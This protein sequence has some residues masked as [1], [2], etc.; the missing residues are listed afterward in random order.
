MLRRIVL[1]AAAIV[2]AACQRPAATTEV[3]DAS[4]AVDAKALPASFDYGL[5]DTDSAEPE[6]FYVEVGDAPTQGP[7][8]AAITIVMFSDFE[9]PFCIQGLQTVQTLFERYPGKIRFAY[10]AFPLD[11]H[12]NALLAAMAARTAQAQGKFWPF[13]NLLFSQRGI[14]PQRVF[15]YAEQA[16]LDVPSLIKDLDALEFGPEVS[17][18]M[19]QARR[20]GVRS[21]P[22]F[23]INGREI[24]GAKPIAEFE[25]LID[26]ELEL[27]ESWLQAGTPLKDVYA[28]AIED[29]YRKVEFTRR[30]G[31]DPDKVFVVPIADSPRRGPDTAPVTIVAFG[32]FE[33]PF[34]V[35][36]HETLKSLEKA[37]GEKLRFVYKHNPL[38]FHSHAYVA[39]RAA[40]AAQGQGKFW[41]FHDALYDE[42]ADFEAEDLSRIAKR[43]G[44]D[45]RRFRKAM[46]S[47]KLDAPI[48]ADLALAAALGVTGTPAFFINGR[49]IEGAVPELQFRL[50]IEE[51]LDRAAKA[52]EAG[53]SPEKLYDTLTHQA[54]D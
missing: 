40:V 12:P 29:G 35:K 1:C 6:R 20:L 30:R 33:C 8:H 46:N 54:L 47:T 5:E 26:E 41:A 27:V 48:Q 32:D 31:L 18:D 4:R 38:P 45:S 51:E 52:R 43:V 15:A 13:H 7:E 23:F 11:M 25:G 14:D 28:K 34:C 49:P 9:C 21:T 36:G 53:V 37:Y 10:K 3:P 22:T 24:S 39:A 17:R 19:R 50:L 42:Q 2:A 44:L 16:G